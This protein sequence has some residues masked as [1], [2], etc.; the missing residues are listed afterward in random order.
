MHPIGRR[1]FACM[2]SIAGGAR[3]CLRGVRAGFSCLCLPGRL[4]SGRLHH[5]RILHCTGRPAGTAAVRLHIYMLRYC[6]R[7]LQPRTARLRIDRAWLLISRRDRVVD[8]LPRTFHMHGTASLCVCRRARACRA[9][10]CTTARVLHPRRRRLLVYCH[11]SLPPFTVHIY[12]M[13]WRPCV[14][15]S[16]RAGA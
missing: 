2:G 15:V 1:R 8:R 5:V 4:E 7:S 11:R 13:A 16:C 12:M 10:F 14:H 6:R 9:L 3:L